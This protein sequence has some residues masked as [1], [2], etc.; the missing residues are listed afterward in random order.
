MKSYWQAELTKWCPTAPHIISFEDKKR[1]DREKQIKTLKR[2]GG[3]LIT[4]YG[5]VTSMRIDLS[6]MRYDI[7]VVDEGHKAKN[8]NTELRKN[9]VALRVKTHRLILTGTPL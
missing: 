2:E 3:V 4:S 1:S 9:L 6:E 5:M 8:V 7:L